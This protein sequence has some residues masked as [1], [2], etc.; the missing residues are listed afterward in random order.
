MKTKKKALLLVMCALLLVGATVMGTLAYLT[1]TTNT[2]TNTFTVG[3]VTITLDES[4]VGGEGRTSTTQD[5]EQEYGVVV[6]GATF[7]KDPI[8]HVDDDSQSCWVFVKVENDLVT[9]ESD[10]EG[11]SIAAQMAANGWKPLADVDNVYYQENTQ[12]AGADID[13]FETVNIDKDASNAAIEALGEEPTIV[14]TAYAI[15][16]SS[17]YTTAAAA[18]TAGGF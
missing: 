13:V 17:E 9:V 10:E 4:V 18:W 8:V 15:Q 7:A 5:V 11:E 2:V 3:D 1:D 16:T 6:P 12:S 14:V